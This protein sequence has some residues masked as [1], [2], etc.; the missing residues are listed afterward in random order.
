MR[1]VSSRLA[2]VQKHTLRLATIGARHLDPQSQA[3]LGHE[4]IGERV[5]NEWR[6]L[7]HV[8]TLG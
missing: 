3:M 5:V 4:W 6:D 7:N 8:S 2:S 1:K